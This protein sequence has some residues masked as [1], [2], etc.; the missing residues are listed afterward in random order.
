M[1][2]SIIAAGASQEE[3]SLLV[4]EFSGEILARTGSLRRIKTC[5]G[6]VEQAISVW[7]QRQVRFFENNL[8]ASF[9]FVR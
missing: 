5:T 2:Q 7:R 6:D 9:F 8:D 4:T 1:E 3:A